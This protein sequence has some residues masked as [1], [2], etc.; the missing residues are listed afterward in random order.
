MVANQPPPPF[1]WSDLPF[2]LLRWSDAWNRISLR[3]FREHWDIPADDWWIGDHYGWLTGHR[4]LAWE[5]VAGKT[6]RVLG[7]RRGGKVASLLVEA[8]HRRVTR[9]DLER[10]PELREYE[11]TAAAPVVPRRKW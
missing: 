8:M 10:R 2:Y 5:W 11:R 7:W 3:C 1:R 9:Q 4:G 6:R